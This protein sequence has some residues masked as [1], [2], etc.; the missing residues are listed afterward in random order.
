M[1]PMVWEGRGTWVEGVY[2]NLSNLKASNEINMA[3]C[4]CA[5]PVTNLRVQ[6]AL[7]R[8]GRSRERGE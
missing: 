1:S 4:V 8:V 6:E 3:M 7:Q 5:F 2:V